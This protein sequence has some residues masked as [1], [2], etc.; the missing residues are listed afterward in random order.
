MIHR[1]LC[2]LTLTAIGAAPVYSQI[3]LNPVAE[4]AV[5]TPQ[6][7]VA[8]APQSPNLVEGREFYAPQSVALDTSASPPILYVSDY[9]NNRV[10]AWKNAATFTKGQKADLAIGQPNLLTT[11]PEGPALVAQKTSTM[12]S[13]LTRPSGLAVDANGNL[14]VVDGGNNRVLR[15]PKPFAQTNNQYPE[16]DL[17]IGQVS[18]SG[19]GANY[20]GNTSTPT[21]QGLYFSNGG[22]PLVSG[23][24]FDSSGNLWVIDT[25]NVR[26]LRFNAAS[27]AGGGG[28]LTADVV[29]GQPDFT[30]NTPAGN[31]A[32]LTQFM[33]PTSLA[34]DSSGNLF[35]GDNNPQ[36]SQLPC[37]RVVMFQGPNLST[38][39]SASSHMAGVFPSGYTFP[40]G[41]A[42]QT[43][44]D[45]TNV[46]LPSAIFFLANGAGMG[47]VDAGYSRIMIFPAFAN[48]PANDAPPVETAIVGQ[49]NAT[50]TATTNGSCKAAN[51]GNPQA[52][53]ATLSGPAGVAYTGTD[54]YIADAL[55]NRVL[56]LPQ[57]GGTFGPASRWL[58]QDYDYESAPNL[59]EGREFEFTG[60]ANGSTFS[61]A[62]MAIDNSSGT[63]HL[64]VADPY[65]NRVLG[66]KDLRTFQNNGPKADIVLGQ[67]DFT[68]SLVN[69]PSGNTNTPNKSGLNRPIGLLVDAQG[70]LYVADSLNGRVLR[71][72]APFSY[73]GAAPEPAD[74]VLGQQNFNAS[75]PD[76]TANNMAIPYGLAFS[77]S[78]NTPSQAC[79]SPNGLLVSDEYFNR[80]L[81]I[82]TT[83]GTFVAGTDNGKAATTVFGQTSFNTGT[84]GSSL[85]Q[86][87]APH[88][89]SSDTSG[90]VYVADS[91]NNRV[92]IFGDPHSPGTSA[93]G[94]T[95]SASINGLSEPEGVYV[96][97]VTGEIWV[98]NCSNPNVPSCTCP[99]G[100][101]CSLRYASYQAVLLNSQV[102][103]SQIQE[104]SGN[105]DF[106]PLAVTQDQY[107]DL[108]VAD[109]AHRVAIYYPGVNLCNGASFLPVSP[110]SSQ[111]PSATCLTQYNLSGALPTRFLAPGAWG[112]IK[113]CNNCGASQFLANQ[114]VST[115]PFPLKLG[116]VQVLFDGVPAPLYVVYPGQ[117]NFI[118]PN[119]ARISGSADL[120]VVQVSTG[121]V[122]GAAQV[123]MNS[124]APGAFLCPGGQSGSAVYACAVNE[125]GTINSASNPAQ[126]GNWVSLYMTGQGNIPGLPP[127]GTAATSAMAAQYPVTVLIN[128]IDVNDPEY[129]E[130]NINHILYSGINGIPGDWQINVQIPK[131]V[132]PKNGAVWF[133]AIINQVPNWD[134]SSPFMT[135]IYVK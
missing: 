103:Y 72:P 114:N 84:A 25:G 78:C 52:S 8:N 121:Q 126:R 83:N 95:A 80:V 69:Y 47:V 67:A 35:V 28:G 119:S 53:A 22:A 128:G 50:C 46:V 60:S 111:Y 19:Y 131:T 4:R 63:P 125:D 14:Y 92:L 66:F 112:T 97:P 23:L 89:I 135:Y 120:Q 93:T 76:L 24:A 43:L 77:P 104:A 51:N 100:T 18:P 20:P 64:Y 48:W 82:P 11:F 115:I 107:G 42:L 55:N 32:S 30:H 16:P 116:D 113:P 65:N 57:Q 132:V 106:S 29:I 31:L 124:V 17:W 109:N 34:F 81:Y 86:M 122:L 85:S 21:A 38:G 73:I 13:G 62:G 117:I 9:I 56:D 44:F 133:A 129:Q 118:V 39:M 75:I 12:T 68:T 15:Y 127:D 110:T 90:L 7:T 96:S 49:P 79:P 58:G 71:F 88:H 33:S 3:T 61:D 2:V 37:G 40:A 130:Q 91:G 99:Q 94:A 1:Y 123:P 45:Q 87:N 134:E 74:L 5:G 101:P 36:C 108:F 70:N 10:L 6:L 102:T 105:F 41:A 27:L 59:I 54:L 26:I 98:A